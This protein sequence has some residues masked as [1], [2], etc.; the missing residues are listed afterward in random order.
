MNPI[1]CWFCSN[2]MSCINHEGLYQCKIC[3]LTITWSHKT[4]EPFLLTIS[5]K[6]NVRLYHYFGTT[7]FYETY[8]ELE[9]HGA[10]LAQ[11]IDLD[12]NII[13]HN[14]LDVIK[15]KINLYLLLS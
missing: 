12:P 2:E 14:T 4:K 7:S 5:I 1:I 13:Y 6:K 11:Y 8:L 15:E 9:H 3:K 10:M